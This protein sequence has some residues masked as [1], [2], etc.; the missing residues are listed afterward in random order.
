MV[1]QAMGMKVNCGEYRSYEADFV[2]QSDHFP[3]SAVFQVPVRLGQPKGKDKK[4]E[5]SVVVHDLKWEPNRQFI[6]QRV[7][8]ESQ[9]YVTMLHKFSLDRTSSALA[10]LSNPHWPEPIKLMASASE[11]EV[12]SNKLPR[13]QTK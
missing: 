13:R 8:V 10:P 9:I 5:M 6:D 3:V 2:S 12:S 11:A 4:K 7:E 1:F